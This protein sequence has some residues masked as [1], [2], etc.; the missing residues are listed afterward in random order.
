MGRGGQNRREVTGHFPQ[1]LATAVRLA[2][3]WA[4]RVVRLHVVLEGVG[5][6]EVRWVADGAMRDVGRGGRGKDGRGREL[7]RRW[8]PGGNDA[9][10]NGGQSW[11]VVLG[12]G[13]E[14]R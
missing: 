9:M 11:V 12:E 13:A 7:Q 10:A 4:G 5:W 2:A 3:L 1:Y 8:T 6:V 14:P